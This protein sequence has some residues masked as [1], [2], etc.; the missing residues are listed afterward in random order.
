MSRHSNSL[1]WKACE[2]LIF[3]DGLMSPFGADHFFIRYAKKSF[4]SAS[5]MPVVRPSGIKEIGEAVMDS[6]SVCLSAVL[7]EMPF[8]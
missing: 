6:M 8:A 5:L 3:S 1:L 2:F 7:L 4:K